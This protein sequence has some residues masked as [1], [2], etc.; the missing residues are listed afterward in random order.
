M[1]AGVE[2]VV[3]IFEAWEDTRDAMKVFCDLSKAFDG[4]NHEALIRKLHHC[5][6]TGCALELLAS[7]LIDRVQK[8][9]VQEGIFLGLQISEPLKGRDFERS[10]SGVGALTAGESSDEFLTRIKLITLDP[11]LVLDRNPVLNV[12]SG[13]AFSSDP[14]LVLDSAFRPAC[15]SDSAYDSVAAPRC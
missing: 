9:K 2:L 14:G 11:T 13:R 15:N 8:T 6:V 1:D 4:V 12:A 7:Y 10:L 3:K 5:G